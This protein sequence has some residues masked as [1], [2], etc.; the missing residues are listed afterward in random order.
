MSRLEKLKSLFERI[1]DEIGIGPSEDII[2]DNKVDEYIKNF[3]MEFEEYKVF[4]ML[5]SLNENN[6]KSL[7]E[8]LNEI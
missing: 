4:D 7:L 2:D 3:L 6:G 5:K 1:D 8:E